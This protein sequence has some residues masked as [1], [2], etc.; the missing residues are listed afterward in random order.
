MALPPDVAK[1]LIGPLKQIEKKLTDSNSSNDQ[2][3]CG[4]F[5]E[6]VNLVNE[7][8]GTGLLTPTQAQDLNNTAQAIKNGLGCL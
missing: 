1:D 5:D 2:S 4:K 6:F 8:E 7:N 3:A